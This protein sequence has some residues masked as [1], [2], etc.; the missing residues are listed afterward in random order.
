MGQWYRAGMVVSNKGWF[1][2][3]E[4][5]FS[6]RSRFSVW[7]GYVVKYLELRWLP[8]VVSVRP[9]KLWLSLLLLPLFPLLLFAPFPPY[10]FFEAVSHVTKAI[11]QACFLTKDGLELPILLSPPSECWEGGLLRICLLG[12]HV[13]N[14]FHASFLMWVKAG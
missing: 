1:N 10:A 9:N 3:L 5:S 4:I 7:N 11:L 8:S 14:E 2:R 13:P 6:I 12:Q